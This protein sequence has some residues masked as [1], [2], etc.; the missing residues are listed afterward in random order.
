ML[1]ELLLV[2]SPLLLQALADEP[3]IDIPHQHLSAVETS[4]L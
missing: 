3:P 2:L 1:H 4:L